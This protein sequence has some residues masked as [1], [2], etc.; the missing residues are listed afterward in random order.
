MRSKSM[1]RL[2]DRA[3][4]GLYYS[5]CAT[6]IGL[7][8]VKFVSGYDEDYFLPKW[9]FY[10]VACFEILLG[11]LEQREGFRLLVGRSLA[12][13]LLLVFSFKSAAQ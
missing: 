11:P 5:L 1:S 6:L 12:R 10:G 2:S 3:G 7:G 8:F 13:L 9:I 4:V